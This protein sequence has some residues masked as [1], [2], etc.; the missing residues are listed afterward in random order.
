MKKAAIDI[1][2]NSTRL[3]VAEISD[4]NELQ[5][6]IYEQ[7]TTRLGE[8]LYES[9]ELSQFSIDR[10]LDVLAE[11]KQIINKASARMSNVVATSAV[12]EADNQDDFLQT[13]KRKMGMTCTVLSGEQEA[14]LT[15]RGVKGAFRNNSHIFVSDIGGGSTE[16]VAEE[17]DGK[18]YELSVLIGSR[19]MTELFLRHDPVE[20]VEMER[21][22]RYVVH[23]LIDELSKIPE[24]PWFCVASGGTATSLALMDL[25]LDI[26]QA[27]RAHGHLLSNAHLDAIIDD[28]TLKSV[29]ERRAITGLES[30]RADVILAGAVILRAIQA[31]WTVDSTTISTWDLLHGLL[32]S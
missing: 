6:L 13:I 28:L 14:H 12:R 29:K 27:S 22:R 3:L 7:R 23:T 5:P 31:Y 2:T 11:Y 9:G 1:G 26:S 10:V 15:L 20:E 24:L 17:D 18:T 4:R 21:L 32:L 25:N 30:E 8:G 19:R 16:F